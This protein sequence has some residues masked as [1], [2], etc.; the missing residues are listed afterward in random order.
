MRLQV[1]NMQPFSLHDGPGIRTTIFLAGCPLRCVWCH[2]PETHSQESTLLFE[3][4]K[5]ILCGDCGICPEKV[6]LFDTKHIL[7]REK[8][9]TCG[10]CVAVCPAEALRLSVSDMNKEKF[11]ALVH[12]QTALYGDTGGITFSG[13]EPLMQG[14]ALLSMLEGVSVHTAIETCG[15]AEERLFCKVIDAM[16]YIMFD[17]KIADN[18]RHIQYTGRGNAEILRNLKILMESG[19]PYCIRTPLIPGITDTEE[20]LLA[21]KQL[22]GESPWEKIEYNMLAPVKYEKIGK[23]YPLSYLHK[24]AGK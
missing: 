21:I 4:E 23:E 1:T 20:N 3:K 16:D 10:Q 18:A 2:N 7:A 8:C 17:V 14:E 22:I 24:D 12:E 5:C 13:G 9:C 15:Y 11:E 19:K 6:H